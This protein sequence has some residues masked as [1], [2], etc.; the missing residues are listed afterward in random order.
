MKT[1]NSFFISIIVILS[2]IFVGCKSGTKYDEESENYSLEFSH[3]NSEYQISDK[4]RLRFY[5]I[6]ISKN[7]L[8]YLYPS[9][10]SRLHM[11]KDG[12]WSDLGSWYAIAALAPFRDTLSPNDTLQLPFLGYKSVDSVGT[13]RVEISVYK[14]SLLTELLPL[15]ERTTNPFTI[16]Y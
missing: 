16:I 11:H 9:F 1:K 4:F 5:A 10:I 2:I 15:N 3:L 14:D 6:N 7:D 12:E 13:Y 8:Y